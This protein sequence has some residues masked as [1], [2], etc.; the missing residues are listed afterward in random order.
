MVT[1]SFRNSSVE[2]DGGGIS[3]YYSTLNIT[4]NCNFRDNSA[5]VHGGGIHSWYSNVTVSGN[6]TFRNNTAKYGGGT[7]AQ[8]STL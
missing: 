6:S 5:K 1:V 3:T 8:Y 7:H 2:M 4:G